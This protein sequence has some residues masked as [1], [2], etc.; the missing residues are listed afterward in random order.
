[1]APS[2]DMAV[3]LSG[4][5][6]VGELLDDAL[7]LAAVHRLKDPVGIESRI[8]DQAA[9][10]PPLNQGGNRLSV[11]ALAGQKLEDD[12]VAE[13][14][15]QGHDLACRA[16]ARAPDGL[17]ASPPFAPWP[18]RLTLTMVPSIIAYSSKLAGRQLAE[19]GRHR[20]H[21]ASMNLLTRLR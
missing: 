21:S 2:A 14:V 4:G 20:G 11:V 6:A 17:M 16:P 12:R 18:W 13:R 3:D 1:M 7:G 10:R 19:L 8:A 9:E 5:G 15:G